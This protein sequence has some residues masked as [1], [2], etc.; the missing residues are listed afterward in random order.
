MGNCRIIETTGII[1][2]E[3]WE[4]LLLQSCTTMPKNITEN[5]KKLGFTYIGYKRC[6]NATKEESK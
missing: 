1:L 3:D 2:V 6:S 4:M 5:S